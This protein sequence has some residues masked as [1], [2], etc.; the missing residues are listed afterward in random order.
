MTRYFIIIILLLFLRRMHGQDDVTDNKFCLKIAPLSLLDIYGGTSARIGIEYK[1]K[2]N[3]ALYN[4]I[5]T[6]FPN[7]NGMHNNYGGL[8]KIEFKIYL[9]KS[10]LTV[11]PYLSAELF[12][13]HQSY[14][15]YDSIYSAAKYNRDYYVSKDVACFTI[16]YGFFQ[17]LKYN[18][19]IDGFVGLG[20]RQKFITN[21]LTYDENNHMKSEG[22]YGTNIAKSKA[23]IF[24]YL[25]FDTGVKIGYRFK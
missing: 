8:V 7:A 11:G 4:E 23:G 16:K 19:V 10:E 1:L 22:D 15:T 3:F 2:R 13:K 25:N 17:V 21:T 5:G 14:Y 24:T 20:V 18:F 9:N 6:Y 12:Y